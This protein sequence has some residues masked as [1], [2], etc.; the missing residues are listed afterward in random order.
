[1]LRFATPSWS[2]PLLLA[3]LAVAPSATGEPATPL[4]EKAAVVRVGET[5]VRAWLADSEEKRRRGLMGV[6]HLAAD[7]GM[8]FV[9]PR[10]AMPR[11]WMRNTPLNLDIGFFDAERTLISYDHMRANDTD[12]LHSPPR[13]AK[14]ALE[15]T[16]GW[17]SA[18]GIEPGDLLELPEGIRAED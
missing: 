2:A 14:Y 6:E 11:F 8:L 5:Q 7:A 9:F 12:T 18:N 4:P 3:L 16:A 1:M 10:P 15:V 13:P 17:F